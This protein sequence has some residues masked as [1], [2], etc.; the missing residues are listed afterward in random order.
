MSRRARFLM[1]PPTH[2]EV[3]Y[4]INPWMRDHV[5]GVRAAAAA[6]QW[7]ALHDVIAA[8]ADVVRIEP[9][10]GLPDMPFTANAG[11]VCGDRFVPSRF[12]HPQR[13]GEEAHFERWF[14][15]AGFAV[16]ALPDDLYFEG[17]G[18]ALL[19]R[20]AAR[21]WMGHGH[22]T[23]AGCAAVLQAM[24]GLEV[25]PLRLVDDRFYHL[26]TCFCP[27]QGGRLLYYPAAFDADSLARI[28]ARVPEALRVAVDE[29]DALAFACNAVDLGDAVALNRAGPALKRAL[30]GFGY[31]TL[32]VPLD[33]FMKS[34]GSAKCLT[35]RLDEDAC[36]SATGRVHADA[37]A[38]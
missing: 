38:R 20:G 25:V 5:A 13:R 24:L 19:D 35:L 15:D 33:E 9:A 10:A 6:A 7:Q 17:A 2:F 8:R 21:L 34:G 16:H 26:D 23:D 36:T 22:R 12:R 14:A 4:V 32:E 27:L 18:D 29:D 28:E 37:A 11:L 30:H 31:A 3:A 1:C